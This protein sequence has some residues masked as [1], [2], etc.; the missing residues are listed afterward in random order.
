MCRKLLSHLRF[1]GLALSLVV[2]FGCGAKPKIEFYLEPTSGAQINAEIDS[3]TGTITV[4]Q[5]GVQISLEPLDEVELFDLTKGSEVNPY[6][7]IG[8]WGKVDP[9]YTIFE[10][11]VY[12][13]EHPRV[14]VGESVVLI[15]DRGNQYASLTYDYFRDLYANSRTTT[16]YQRSYYHPYSYYAPYSRYYPTYSRRQRNSPVAKNAR[17]IVRDTI[18]DG[19][20]IFPGGKR[21]GFLVFD[22]LPDDTKDLEVIVPRVVV[23]DESDQTSE[24][25]FR[26]D[27]Q[28]KVTVEN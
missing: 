28:Q 11:L 8:R 21:V 22:R 19:G 9:L 2:L 16:T 14:M 13:A 15:D 20:Q 27:F 10:I 1:I 23:V 18:F 26:F 3:E 7:H 6:L 25:D 12:N 4:I 17:L 5:K 24:I